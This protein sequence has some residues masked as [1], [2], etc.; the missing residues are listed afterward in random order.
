MLAALKSHMDRVHPS[1]ALFKGFAKTE[2]A[3]A[4]LVESILK[5]RT[6]VV[7]GKKY[8]DIFEKSGRGVRTTLDG[9]FVT[10]VSK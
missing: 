9:S 8:I 6:E 7:Q 3:A 1:S 5:N 4:G 2:E 10:F